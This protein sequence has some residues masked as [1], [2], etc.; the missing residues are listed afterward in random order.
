MQTTTNEQIKTKKMETVKDLQNKWNVKPRNNHAEWV[1]LNK[2]F[3]TEPLDL[4]FSN[5]SGYHEARE[6]ATYQEIFNLLKETT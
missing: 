5:F 6:R 3:G 2:Y 1:L 4:W